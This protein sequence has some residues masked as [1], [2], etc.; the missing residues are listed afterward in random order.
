LF[1][2]AFDLSPITTPFSQ[3]REKKYPLAKRLIRRLAATVCSSLFGLAIVVPI[4]RLYAPIQLVAVAIQ[5]RFEKHRFPVRQQVD[6]E[7]LE[8][9]Q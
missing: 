3:R 7:S 9:L 4:E 1:D 6:A 8:Y 2:H 5:C